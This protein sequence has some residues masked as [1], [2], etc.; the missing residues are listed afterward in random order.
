MNSKLIWCSAVTDSHTTDKEGV[1]N[2]RL[3]GAKAY[4]YVKNADALD[5]AL[6]EIAFHKLS[7]QSTMYQNV[8]QALTANLSVLGGVVVSTNGLKSTT[9]GA[10]YGWIQ[11]L[12]YNGSISVSGATTGGADILIGEHL[13]GA[14]AVSYAVRDTTAPTYRRT[15]Q[16]LQS[17]TTAETPAAALVKGTIFAL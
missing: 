6:G 17:V 3:S 16:I 11:V 2:L 7:D 14:N 15:I 13:K 8:Y 10:C 4:R 1:G 9:G 5:L 12:G